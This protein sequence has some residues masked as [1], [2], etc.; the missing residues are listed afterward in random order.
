MFDDI[1]TLFYENVIVAYKEFL[2]AKTSRTSGRSRD[3]K[4]G[5]AAASAMYHFREH[6]REPTL[7]SQASV[8]NS[9]PEY[10]LLGDV[11]NASKHGVL[12]KGTP[13]VQSAKDIQEVV[14]IT[15]LEDEKGVYRMADKIVAVTLVDGTERR[16]EDLLRVVMNF[17]IGELVQRKLI[18][19]RPLFLDPPFVAPTR[20]EC[21]ASEDGAARL[22]FEIVQGVRFKQVLQLKRY[23]VTIGV[24][25]TDP[26][27][28]KTFEFPVTLSTRESTS[29]SRCQTEAAKLE[30]MQSFDSFQQATVAVM[31][32]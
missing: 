17:W 18:P 6:L 7:I 26:K 5:I 15:E 22:D 11:V 28:G 16:L 8:R 14:V 2:E 29:L 25:L 3:V 19:A 9:C 1:A 32:K 30:M 12:S 27:S 31:S 24:T 20:E 4:L 21:G 10:G 13:R 23:Q